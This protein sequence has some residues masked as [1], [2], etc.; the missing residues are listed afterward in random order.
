MNCPSCSS[1]HIAKNGS[2]GNGKPKFKYNSCGRQFVENP[3]KQ[4]ISEATKQLI[5]KLLLEKSL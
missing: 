5:D 4:T 1:N 2:L 3:K